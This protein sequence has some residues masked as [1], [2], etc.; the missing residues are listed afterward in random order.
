MKLTG[1]IRLVFSVA[2][3]VSFLTPALSFAVQDP[4]TIGQFKNYDRPGAILPD[5]GTFIIPEELKPRVEFWKKIYSRY[6]TSQVVLHDKKHLDI[7]YEVIDIKKAFK[8]K[9]PSRGARRNFL[10][11]RK[12]LIVNVLKRL[13]NNKG[14]PKTDLEKAIVAKFKGINGYKKYRLATK[15]VRVQLGQADRFREGVK[16]SGK[17]ID[18]MRKIFRSYG[19]PEELCALPH[20]ESSFNY[21]AYSSAGASGVWQF[22]RGTGRLFM[23]VNYTVDERRDPIKSTVAAARLL[24]Q[25][26]RELKSWPLAVTA[27][28]HGTNGMKRAKS[29]FGPDI[30]KVI[31]R[32]KSRSFGFA[33][34]NF[35]TEF[36]AALHVARNYERYFGK[37]HFEESL[38]Y[39]KVKIPYYL[40]ANTL[41]QSTGISKEILKD[42]NPALRTSVWRGS[43]HVPKGYVLMVPGGRGASVKSALAS[44]PDKGR[45]ESQKSSGFHVVSRGETLSTIAGRY[46]V[47]LSSLRRENNIWS[48]A[49]RVG[50]KLRIPGKAVK[51]PSNGK[52]RAAI[53]LTAPADGI[54]KVRRGDNPYDIATAY[55]MT[56]SD[57]LRINGLSKRSRIY[58]GQ[59][60]KVVEPEK[61]KVELEA[62]QVAKV[63]PQVPGIA[64][65]EREAIESK[66]APADADSTLS[67][68]FSL[69]EEDF[70]ARRVGK[71]S[72]VIM[73]ESEETLGHY[74]DWLKVNTSAIQRLNRKN[75]RRRMNIGSKVTIPL[76]KVSVREFERK[77]YE[78]HMSLMEDFLEV[79]TVTEDQNI[80]IRRGQS[81]WE[82]CVKK[83]D[84]PL[85]LVRM[86]NPGVN[87]GS[88]MPGDSI[89]MPMVVK[90]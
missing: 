49:I 86:Y 71:R 14:V 5:S 62:T 33:S 51:S 45:Y 19:L 42:F 32:Y 65:V 1:S 38:A 44:T 57:L 83:H 87:L 34:A 35:Y 29:K 36:L 6:T 41:A 20:V 16:R 70:R 26:Y 88:V 10:K 27:Y 84:A 72:A 2:I 21:K 77:R 31:A 55:N 59:H 18:H 43:R 39:E 50:Q 74:A 47:R 22:T 11:K 9:T 52:K 69:S 40:S 15:R 61:A 23:R 17:Y 82:L 78:Y 76:S 30:V 53:P 80:T 63:L 66:P 13:Y 12:N 79:Y 48:D 25:N 7:V 46:R 73:V 37:L 90:K 89:R 8:G 3:L 85:W 56:L 24:K 60:L 58:P 68:K 67:V 28:N 81:M 75:L 64:P 54:H 4:A